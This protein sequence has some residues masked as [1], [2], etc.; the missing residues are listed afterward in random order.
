MFI[1]KILEYVHEKKCSKIH[2]SNL[3]FKY[4]FK[5]CRNSINFIVLKPLRPAGAL[6]F[7]ETPK[8]KRKALW[9]LWFTLWGGRIDNAPKNKTRRRS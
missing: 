6:Y 8:W 4:V 3:K 9:Y 5:N 1:Y 2:Y 7:W